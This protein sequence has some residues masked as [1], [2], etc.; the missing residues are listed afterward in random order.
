MTAIARTAAAAAVSGAPPLRRMCVAPE[1]KEMARRGGGKEWR[2][3][4]LT[5]GEIRRR[6]GR[7]AEAPLPGEDGAPAAAC[8]LASVPKREGAWQCKG[9]DSR[10]EESRRRVDP[11]HALGQ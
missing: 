11:I 7:A 2:D 5:G 1:R 9:R 4:K 8:S 6:G 3:N 10:G